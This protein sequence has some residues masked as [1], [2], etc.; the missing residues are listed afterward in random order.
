MFLQ[1]AIAVFIITFPHRLAP[2]PFAPSKHLSWLW[3]LDSMKVGLLGRIVGFQTI[4]IESV[5]KRLTYAHD[6]K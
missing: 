4:F 3:V 6:A 5:R 2:I 1:L